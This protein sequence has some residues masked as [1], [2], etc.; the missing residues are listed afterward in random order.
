MDLNLGFDT[1]CQAESGSGPA[2]GEPGCRGGGDNRLGGEERERYPPHTPPPHRNHTPLRREVLCLGILEIPSDPANNA[3]G[4][5]PDGLS[6]PPDGEGG[7]GGGIPSG[8]A[9]AR[10]SGGPPGSHSL[11][12]SLDSLHVPAGPPFATIQHLIEH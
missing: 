7:G 10:R 4:L 2:P 1:V 6:A 5:R 3:D 8:L 11:R 9:G 12:P